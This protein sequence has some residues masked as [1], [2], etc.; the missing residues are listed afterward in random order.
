MLVLLATILPFMALG[1]VFWYL[2]FRAGSTLAELLAPF[3]DRTKG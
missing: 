3:L 2:A 1:F